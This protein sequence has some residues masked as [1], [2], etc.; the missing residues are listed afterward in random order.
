MAADL[1]RPMQPGA[2]SARAIRGGRR[3]GRG[4]TAR[5]AVRAREEV[6]A[7]AAPLVLTLPSIEC[8]T[9]MPRRGHPT[10]NEK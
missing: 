5:A 9:T 10:L 4:A 1:R 7:V 6:E 3:A 2:Q 8:G